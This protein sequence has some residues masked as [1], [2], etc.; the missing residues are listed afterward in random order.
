MSDLNSFAITGRLTKDASFMTVGNGK[1]LL[2]MDVAVNTGFGDNKKTMYVKVN[3]WSDRGEKIVSYLKKGTLVAVSGQ[4]SVDTWTGKSGDQH[5]DLVLTTFNV[6]FYNTGNGNTQQSGDSGYRY[7]P[8]QLK[9][10]E[11]EPTF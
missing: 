1:P 11:P 4:L 5:Q 7:T 10:S 8:R 2:T 6:D 9:E 3:M